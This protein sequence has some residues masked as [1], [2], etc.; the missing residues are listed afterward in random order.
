MYQISRTIP[1]K[2]QLD[3]NLHRVYIAHKG[4][5]SMDKNLALALFIILMI[6]VV[7]IV[8]ILFFRDQFWERLISNIG[9][10]L[11]FIAFYLRFLK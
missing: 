10:V 9:I 7:V 3:S 1:R 4:G 2:S 5:T 11:I 6:A 8:D